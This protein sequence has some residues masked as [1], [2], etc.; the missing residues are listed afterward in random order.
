MRVKGVPF[1]QP[2]YIPVDALAIAAA[3]LPSQFKYQ[4]VRYTAPAG[5]LRSSDLGTRVKHFGN[6]VTVRYFTPSTAVIKMAGSEVRQVSDDV[7]VRHLKQNMDPSAKP[8]AG[9]SPRTV[10]R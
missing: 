10:A 9:A 6:D 3:V 2:G 5:Q 4:T 1:A 7:T 8:V